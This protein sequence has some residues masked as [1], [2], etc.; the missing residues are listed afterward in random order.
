MQLRDILTT[1]MAHSGGELVTNLCPWLSKAALDMIGL[2]GMDPMYY[3]ELVKFLTAALGFG[4]KF[5]ALNPVGDANELYVAF[6]N[7]MREGDNYNILHILRN[8]IP[9][10]RQIVGYCHLFLYGIQ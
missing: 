3:I 10:F 4:Y 2:A 8:F 5:D 6:S 1:E 7:A 9:G